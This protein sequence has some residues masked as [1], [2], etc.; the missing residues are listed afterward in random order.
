MND[1]A[2]IQDELTGPGGMFE[3]TET[4]VRGMPMR[5]YANAPSS[6]RDLLELTGSNADQ[7]FLVYRDERL[8]FA[9][10]F[11]LVAGFAQWLAQH[12]GVGK[13]DRVAIGMRNY[14]EW[15]V[16]FWATQVLGAIAVPLNAWWT[17]DELRFA[18]ED[19]GVTS[20]VLDGERYERMASDLAEL[21]IPAVVVRH[22]RQLADGAEAWS[23]VAASFDG[24]AALPSIE[25]DPEDPSTIIYTSGTTGTPKG[26]ISTHRNHVTTFMNMALNG[27]LERAV[28]PPADDATE[29]RLASM[30]VTF[31]FFHVGGIN[32][33]ILGAGFGLKL[34]LLYKWD[35]PEALAMIER[36]RVTTFAAVPTVLREF[37]ES[38]LRRDHDLSSLSGLT[39]GAAAVPPDLVP[40]IKEIF[41]AQ[42]GPTTSYGL[43]EASGA[44]T[45]HP[46]ADYLRLPM[47]VGRPFP[48]TDVRVVDVVSREVLGTDAVGELCFRGPSI[49][50]GYW[51]REA[52]T[53]AAFTDGW[54]HT[55]DVGYLDDDG[56]VYVVDR[57]K[58]VVIRGGENVYSAEVEA[59]LFEHPAVADVAIVGVPHRELGEQVA[60]VVRLNDGTTV[61]EADLQE[62]VAGRLAYFKVPELIV[63]RTE[64]IP[65]NATGKVL[66]RD[67]RD[68]LAG[69]EAAGPG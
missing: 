17:A 41:G 7:D 56:Y 26:A 46:P 33:V 53:A 51:N 66:K 54:F 9:D 34:V 55:G 44:A 21:G 6:T 64:P 59:V 28:A 58:D 13:G 61:S 2:R 67:L 11:Q 18:L 49:V 25:L 38:P 36:E 10:H 65:R 30:L 68:E 57:L 31:P 29:S 32:L 22:D 12:H 45:V 48:V 62:H 5:V 69:A 24:S 40:T 39:G 19:S 15:S 4:S 23:S 16:A 27:M 60:A 47:S 1:R 14:P 52:E 37:L 63:F 42:A 35:L 8:T 3:I 20:S 43:T 50:I